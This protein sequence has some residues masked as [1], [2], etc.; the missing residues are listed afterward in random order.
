[1]KFICTLATMTTALVPLLYAETHLDRLQSPPS[2]SAQP[3]AVQL[4]KSQVPD[5]G[6][7]TR[8]TDEQQ[9][10]DF[11]KYF[12][13]KWNFSWE[14]PDGVLGPGGTITGTVVYK[15]IEGPFY[16]AETNATGPAG[17]FTVK[18]MIAYRKEGK[19]AA[20]WLVD[21]RGFSYQQLGKVGGDLGGYFNIYY[22]GAPFSYNGNE[23]R[24]KNSMHLLSPVRYKNLV[25]VST[26]GGRFINYGSP[27][28]EKDMTSAT[29]KPDE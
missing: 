6:R 12:L 3:D 14:I 29:G 15:Q 25:T 1:M 9:A 16:E 13:G 11:E 21:S 22:E 8:A 10:L 17:P 7:P 20:R 4:P 18:E 28:Y 23:V 5:L 27:W 24:L 26:N 19:T 2:P